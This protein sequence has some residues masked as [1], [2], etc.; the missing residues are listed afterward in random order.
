MKIN[1]LKNKTIN[2]ILLVISFSIIIRFLSL[3][4]RI[5]LNRYL[6]IEGV[7]LYTISIPTIMLFVSL[8]GISLNTSINQ[9]VSKNNK[10][11][12]KRLIKDA[13]ILSI[14]TSSI[15]SLI[16]LIILNPLSK[17]FL[18]SPDVFYPI[19]SS[20]PLIYLSSITSIL[21][22]IHNG[23]SEV[24]KSQFSILIEQIVRILF[25]T[26]LI[27]L[28]SNILNSVVYAILAMSIGEIASTIYLLI[29]FK[30][31]INV[32][33]ENNYTKKILDLSIPSTLSHL[34]SSICTF[35]EPIIFTL[36]FTKLNY[37][38][39]AIRMYYSEVS[40]YIIPTIAMF[41]FVSASISPIL[42][43]KSTHYYINNDK[44]S[45]QNLISK[46]LLIIIISSI[47]ILTFLYHYGN[48]LIKILYN[49]NIEE[50]L[51][52]KY[53]F[54]FIFV[55][56]ES[57]LIAIIQG[58][59]D[60]KKIFNTVLIASIIKLSLLII[61]PLL[62]QTNPKESIIISYLF[63]ISFV[64]I[65]SYLYIRKKLDYRFPLKNLVFILIFTLFTI[66]F[67]TF[68]NL[69]FLK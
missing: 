14:I 43:Q 56:I 30:D 52:K 11:L 19:I 9:I 6:G 40:A 62:I 37:E 61:L 2:S 59:Q 3:F 41:L 42:I 32:N 21:R 28:S 4:N 29:K 48:Q 20:I 15:S 25:Q 65:S 24:K 58:L 47:F 53:I 12:D 13:L 54:L 36:V 50:N 67:F 60:N 16:L 46:T 45:L 35:L 51:L 23:L 1:I 27:L 8:G 55:Y 68:L 69:L 26:L 63:S 17:I 18:K 66:S 31:K 57:P 34:S 49:Y 5:V 10:H 33:T 44:K 38:S 39:E 64:S 7:S 22:G